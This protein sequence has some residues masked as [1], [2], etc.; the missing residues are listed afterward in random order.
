MIRPFSLY[1]HSFVL[2]LMTFAER[3]GRFY[4]E[5]YSHQNLKHQDVYTGEV[6]IGPRYLST[7]LQRSETSMPA[8]RGLFVHFDEDWNHGWFNGLMTRGM[9]G[10]ETKDLAVVSMPFVALKIGEVVD[11]AHL[12][13]RR[14]KPYSE[15][16][17]YVLDHA[18]QAMPAL[19]GCVHA[20][21][22]K[23]V[24]SFCEHAL[25]DE[26]KKASDYHPLCMKSAPKWVSERNPH[27][28]AREWKAIVK[29]LTSRLGYIQ[30]A[31]EPS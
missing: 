2:E 15:T 3:D 5:A 8:F 7:M 30:D 19:S 25:G 6:L 13:P 31:A 22:Y 11:I 12:Q 16:E 24:T 27:L 28:N 20:E 1:D 17:I 18:I 21:W 29:D 14:I 9:A 4:I 23:G 26:F 10:R